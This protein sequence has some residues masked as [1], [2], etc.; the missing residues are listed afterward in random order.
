MQA[1]GAGTNICW[2]PAV[3]YFASGSD[4]SPLSRYTARM[5]RYLGG[6]YMVGTFL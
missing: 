6:Q 4:D 5:L 3:K 2:Q 1:P